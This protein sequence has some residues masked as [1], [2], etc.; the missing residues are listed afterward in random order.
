MRD[1]LKGKRIMV[2]T[3]MGNARMY[4]ALRDYG[5]RIDTIGLFSFKVDATGTITESGVAISN[6][7]T[8]INKWPHI[9]WLL[10][11]ANDGANSIFKALRDNTDGA[12]DTFCSEL[13]RIMEKY[14]WCSGVDIDLE[15]GDDYSTHEASTAMFKHIYETVKAYDSTKEMN[16]CLPGMTSVNGSVGGENWCVYGDLDQYCDTASIMS[17]GMAWA[18][19][20]PGPV[21][22]RSWLEG[23]YDYATQVMNPDKVFLGMPA[24]GWNWQIYD[25][26]ENLGKYYRGTS[27]TYYAAKY[28]MQ[29]VYNFT[30]DAPPQ[31]F[32]PIVSYW[33]DYDMGPWAL[34]HVY[35]YM[36]GRDATDYSYPLMTET[37]NR[38]RY[39][40][41]YAKQQHTEFGEII[42]DHDAEPDSY[43]GVVSVSKTL[44][45]LG[46][47]GTATYK[48]TID[49]AGTYD[50]AVR[51]CYPFWDKNSIYAS[52]DG[53][54]VHFSEDR[55][56]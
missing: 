45:T 37:Y 51:L 50:V 47:E 46:D 13:V 10:T 4:E 33:D 41:A 26:P 5:D 34:P 9:R 23:I 27:H 24:Y 39:L 12:Q 17:Y 19:S 8:Y 49:E 1:K 28:W 42:I 21:S 3:F 38:R 29:G 32:I 36:E 7:L 30:D 18:G 43:G 20:A 2:W 52:L 22:P 14:P 11:I 15:K 35:D 56:W 31:P 6:M 55:L 16:I 44:V 25:T 40:T 54:T 48:F 53:S